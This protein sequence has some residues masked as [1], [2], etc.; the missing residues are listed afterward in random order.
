MHAAV[1]DVHHRY[2][3]HVGVGAA[4]VAVQRQLELGGGGL[5]DGQRHAENGVGA[6]PALVVRAVEVDE[7]TVDRRWSRASMPTTASAISPLTCRRRSA[8]LCRDSGR[9]PSR[10]ST[11][12]CSPVDAPDGT[13]ARPSAPRSRQDLDLDGR[14]AAA[15][16]EPRVPRP[17]R[18]RS[19]DRPLSAA[20]RDIGVRPASSSVAHWTNGS[21]GGPTELGIPPNPPSPRP[22]FAALSSGLDLRLR[23]TSAELLGLP[24]IERLG[25]WDATSVAIQ[26]VPVGPSRHLVRFV[27]ADGRLWALKEMPEAI[28]RKEY[29]MLRELEDRDLSAVRAAGMVVQP[30]E[31][32]AVLVTHYLESS[33][34]YRRLL[35]RVPITMRAHRLA[36]ARRH[37]RAARR[38]PPQRLLLG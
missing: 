12:S 10:S 24:W 31:D 25:E 15:S 14:V 28:A 2:R 9:P 33:W 37:R 4:D 3:Q 22:T 30:F 19:P 13:I 27:E 17:G 23:V 5:G 38:P 34:Q 6:E 29:E 21:G 35:M 20:R 18:H 1:E 8:R 36:P 11:A 32:T 16:R 26:D 7:L